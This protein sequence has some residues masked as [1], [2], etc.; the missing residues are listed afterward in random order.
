MSGVITNFF[1]TPD[2]YT[3]D[4]IRVR[5]KNKCSSPFFQRRTMSGVSDDLF[6]T[7]DIITLDKIQHLADSS[8]IPS[9]PSSYQLPTFSWIHRYIFGRHVWR[10]PRREQTRLL[11]PRGRNGPQ[12]K[13]CKASRVERYRMS[14][15]Q[16]IN[17][18][19][20]RAN[21]LFIM[22]AMSERSENI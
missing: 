7:P 21:F 10:S 1:W 5:R 20:P 9:L 4:K 13:R 6:W 18:C 19:S 8:Q 11:L 17:M 22:A 16:K 12:F 15:R 3:P 2:I 14:V